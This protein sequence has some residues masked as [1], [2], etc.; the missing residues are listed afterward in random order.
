MASGR[1][2]LLLFLPLL[3]AM[4]DPFQPVADSC[5][6]AQ[7]SQ[8]RYRG[9]IRSEKSAIGLVLDN[10]GKWHRLTQGQVLENSWRINRL[11]A[12]EIEVRVG[13][14]CEP[15][16]WHWRKEGASQHE[17]TRRV[18]DDTAGDSARSRKGQHRHADRG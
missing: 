17:N 18:S 16:V 15:A 4:R 6:V 9:V 10:A 11:S 2:V 7:L 13:E 5:V 3:L 1:A 14:H 12:E 8:W